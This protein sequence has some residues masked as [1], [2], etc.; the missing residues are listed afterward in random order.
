VLA[1]GFITTS[2]LLAIVASMDRAPQSILDRPAAA[3]A[4]PAEP[5]APR[6]PSAPL[7]D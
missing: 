3:P 2:L 4:A 7:A 6:E 1:A 5:A